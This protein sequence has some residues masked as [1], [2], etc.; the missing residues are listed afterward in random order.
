[1]TT[2]KKWH[3]HFQERINKDGSASRDYRESRL[4]R[5]TSKL[6]NEN[7]FAVFYSGLEKVVS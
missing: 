3:E 7:D 1:M 5:Y 2:R 6:T 4:Q